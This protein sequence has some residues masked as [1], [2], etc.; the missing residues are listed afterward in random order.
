MKPRK[1]I[2]V[3]TVIYCLSGLALG[4]YSAN[5]AQNA[6]TQSNS[7]ASFWTADRI[8]K[9]ISFDMVFENGSKVGKRVPALKSTGK[10]TGGTNTS[11]SVLGASW[12]FGGLPLN[13]TG[14]VFFS[15]GASYYQCSGSLVRDGRSD[16][17]I[18]LTAGHC[19][20]DN[21]TSKYVENWIFIPSYD[22]N[23]VS[24]SGCSTSNMCWPAAGIY[25]HSGFTSETGFT[26][27]ATLHD[28]GFATIKQI[29]NGK[30]PD[31]GDGTTADGTNSFII[32]FSALAGQAQVNSYGYPAS[33]KYN[34]Q[35][36][37]YSSGKIAFDTSNAS[38]TYALA[39]DMT[40]GCSGGPWTSNVNQNV[41]Y[42]GILSSVNSYKYGTTKFIYGPIFNDKTSSTYG[43]A[44]SS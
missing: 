31:G 35:D 40:G 34:G 30:L 22:V 42:D 26:T 1:I 21:A 9:A 28:W 38:Q 41:P 36:L 39:S 20:F 37:V 13:A 2:S 7:A 44:L 25:A 16:R 29:K 8:N 4:T 17:S 15:I 3:V 19:V 27:N 5:A 23:I 14:K 10:P 33:G 24:I 6:S 32:S 12:T 11:S 18:V 43:V